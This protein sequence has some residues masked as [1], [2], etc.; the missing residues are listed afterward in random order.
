MKKAAK[1][2]ATE[3]ARGREEANKGDADEGS[4]GEVVLSSSTYVE[5]VDE[6]NKVNQ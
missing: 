4:G 1:E 5:V 2:V 6:E 3:G